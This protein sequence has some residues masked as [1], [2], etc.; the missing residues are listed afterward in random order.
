MPSWRN[1]YKDDKG[2]ARPKGPYISI[3]LTAL[4]RKWKKRKRSKE[5]NKK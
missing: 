5:K 3:N 2:K 1:Y 4:W